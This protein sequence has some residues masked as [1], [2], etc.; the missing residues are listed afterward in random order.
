[1]KEIKMKHLSKFLYI[2]PAIFI[3]LF[4][5]TP[6]HAQSLGDFT[7]IDN[8]LPVEIE[9]DEALEWQRD[10]E[11]YVAR[12]NAIAR[13]GEVEIGANILIAYYRERPE[14]GTEIWRVAA[15]GNV[16]IKSPESE[17]F[18]DQGI[19]DIPRQVAV[20]TGNNLRLTSETDEITAQDSLEFWQARNIAVARGNA[21]VEQEDNILQADKLTAYFAPN[22]NNRED[23]DKLELNKITA[24]DNVVIMTDE[25]IARGEHAIYDMQ[26]DIALLTGGVRLT[27]GGTQ[28]EGEQVEVNMETGVTTLS[29][30]SGSNVSGT[31]AGGGRVRGVFVPGEGVQ[32]GPQN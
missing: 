4:L 32:I 6:S 25:D 18:G 15:N 27:R 5:S 7:A 23:P 21:R 29:A 16:Y 1:M 11:A 2:F 17:A 3:G 12:G 24:D 14:G 9:A 10:N 22:P 20:L 31:N 30:G 13:R 26:T 19:Y 8:D 28:L